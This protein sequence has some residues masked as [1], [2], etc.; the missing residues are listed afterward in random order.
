M[1][2]RVLAGGLVGGILGGVL[3]AAIQAV[4]ATPLILQAESF[5]TARALDTVR[6]V[7]AAGHAHTAAG[8]YDLSRLLTA[9]G[10]TVAVATG[11]ALLLLSAMLATGREITGRS[12]IPWAM[13]GFFA[14]GLAPAFGMAPEL[15]GSAVADLGARQ[16]WWIGTAVATAAGLAAI[17]LGRGVL[18]IAA[19]LALIALPHLIGAPD[20][21]APASKV[22]AEIAARFAS[23]SLVVQALLWLVP[24]PI[25]G[26]AVAW[27]QGR[28]AAATTGRP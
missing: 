14:T 18:W 13:A 17:G 9:S 27:L 16:L 28:D 5:E 1:L 4:A 6:V 11:Y 19:G 2:A 7:L 15:P 12:V 8:G 24:A 10:A 22:P 23:V 20:A 25:A 21:P 26:I 3:V